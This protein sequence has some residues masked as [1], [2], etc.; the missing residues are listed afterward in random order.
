M[1]DEKENWKHNL[2]IISLKTIIGAAIGIAGGMAMV[3]GAAAIEGVILSWAI[4]AKVL[5]IAGAAGGMTHGIISVI[6][7]NKK[8]NKDQEK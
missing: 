8:K 2:G 4:F 7:K 6:D 1:N 5:G 3:A